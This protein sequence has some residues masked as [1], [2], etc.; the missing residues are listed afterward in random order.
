[1]RPF[2]LAMITAVM[3][4]TLFAHGEPNIVVESL[5]VPL[6]AGAT[7][8]FGGKLV[9]GISEPVQRFGEDGTTVT[10][11]GLPPGIYQLQR[12]LDGIDNWE[13]L[14][15]GQ[16]HAGG[17][18]VF[19]DA[20][21]EFSFSIFY[22]AVAEETFRTFTIRNTGGTTLGS[23]G[24]GIAPQ[25]AGMFDFEVVAFGFPFSLEPGESASFDVVFLPFELGARSVTLQIFSDDPVNGSFTLELTGE[26]LEQGSGWGKSIPL[27]GDVVIAPAT[28]E[29][30]ARLS[31]M[32]LGGAPGA[33][34]GIEASTDLG[35]TG[36]WEEIGTVTLDSNGTATISEL[37]APGSVGAAAN[38]FRL[39]VP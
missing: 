1:M 4:F 21:L 30:P 24:I 31:A 13:V 39:K 33:L 2:P 18:L 34:I 27:L 19:D 20:D 9:F 15:Q 3:Q 23:F 11:P 36:P 32:V 7:V 10:I 26:G 37:S 8:D 29:L 22:R 25:D 16:S 28:S 35:L 14:L 5:D 38:F 17:D 6:E 12:S